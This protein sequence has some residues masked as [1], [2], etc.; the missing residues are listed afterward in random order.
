MS[1]INAV[2]VSDIDTC[3]TVTTEIKKGET[4]VYQASDGSLNSVIA[5]ADVPIYHKIAVAPVKKDD[6]A[7]KYGEKIGQA[8]EDIKPGDYV[9]IHNLKKVGF[10]EE[11]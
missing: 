4:V 1:S 6:Y 7:L 5:K 8:L 3:V 11:A 10:I 9:H 2:H